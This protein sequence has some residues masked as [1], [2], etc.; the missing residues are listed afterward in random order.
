MYIGLYIGLYIGNLSWTEFESYQYRIPFL[1]NSGTYVAIS[2]MNENTV[3]DMFTLWINSALFVKHKSR[4]L[5]CLF[6]VSIICSNVYVASRPFTVGE[7][8]IN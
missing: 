8:K 5:A 1:V 2:I 7:F 4:T 6:G 3:G